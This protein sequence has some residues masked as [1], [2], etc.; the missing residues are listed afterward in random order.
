MNN[1]EKGE[2][3]A[4]LWMVESAAKRKIAGWSKMMLEASDFVNTYLF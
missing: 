3:L 2:H 4:K 1:A